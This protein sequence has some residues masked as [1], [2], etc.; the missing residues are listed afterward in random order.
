MLKQPRTVRRPTNKVG[1]V[2]IGNKELTVVLRDLSTTGA[3]LR[4]VGSGTLPD[5][6]TLVSPLEKINAKCTVVWRRGAD[7]GVKFD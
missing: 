3:R 6:F 1:T 5:E 4:V 2:A 7:C